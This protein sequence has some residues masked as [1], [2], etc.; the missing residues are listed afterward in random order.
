MVVPAG[1]GSADA[2]ADGEAVGL[3]AGDVGAARSTAGA[4]EVGA[5]GTLP[6]TPLPPVQAARS[7]AQGDGRDEAAVGVHG[8]GSVAW[9]VEADSGSRR[10][11]GTSPPGNDPVTGS[12]SSMRSPPPARFDALRLPPRSTACSA[13][14]ARPSPLLPQWRDGSAL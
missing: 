11:A 6:R 2:P 5:G 12:R 4:D 1:L 8:M 7:G 9:V 14:I 13:A 10:V 3:A